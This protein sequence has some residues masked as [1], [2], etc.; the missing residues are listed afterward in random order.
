MAT[1]LVTG[2]AGFIG[3]SVASALLD[4]RETVIGIDNFNDYYAPELKQQRDGLL[5]GRRNYVSIEMDLVD[6]QALAACF[7]DYRPDT[8]CHLAAQAGVRYSLRNPY[9]YQQSNLEGFINVIEQARLSAVS[10]FVYASSSSVYGGNS[11]MPYSE[12]DPV[13]TPVSLYAATKRSN[14]L[15]AHTYT[16][17]W[18]LQ[19]V[20]LRFFTVYGPWGRP[21][22]AY[23]SFLDAMVN[24]EPIRVFNYGKNR[25]DFT[26]IEDVVPAVVASLTAQTL[27]SC[28]IINLGNNRPEGLLDFI[29]TLEELSG[30]VAVKEM[31]PAQPGDVVAT[32]ADIEKA[33]EKLGFSPGTSLRTGLERFVDWYFDHPDLIKAVRAHKRSQ[34]R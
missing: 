10:R 22:M 33:R 8:V 6:R 26:Y 15:I 24:H 31:V 5:L 7:Q 28:E 32:Y 27:D 19:T 4:A 29:Q 1:I 9:V 23:W 17:L 14:E 16:H 2:S 34:R 12:E 3:F 18:G 21:D 20:G 11:K 25:R 30:S 13:N